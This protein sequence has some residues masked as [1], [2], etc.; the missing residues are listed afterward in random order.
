MV[1]E[2][3]DGLSLMRG[4][5][6]RR[7]AVLLTCYK[8]AEGSRSV[9]GTKVPRRSASSTAQPITACL[10]SRIAN[11]SLMRAPRLSGTENRCNGSE[12]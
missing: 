6:S 1:G 11:C 3:L 7:W 10:Q 4:C 8:I 9:G 5:F 2:L 12:K